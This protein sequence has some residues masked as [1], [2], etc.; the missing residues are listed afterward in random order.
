MVDR[1]Q[2]LKLEDA[3]SGTETDPYPRAL[4]RNED[5]VDAHGLALQSTISDDEAVLLERTAGDKLLLKDS[6]Y[7]TGKTLADLAASGSGISAEVHRALRQLIHFIDEG[8]AE[9]FAS[10]AYREVTGTV[11]P[12]AII[13]YDDNTKAKKIV[14][15]NL[16]FTGAFPTTIVWKIYDTDGTTV[17]ATVTDTIVYAG[18]FESSRTRV[19]A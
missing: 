12:S 13:W 2:P 4:D 15:K 14:E 16:T 18:A 7:P 1:V 10:G 6:D 17:L 11:F 5:Y 19:I 3:S 8:P 9:G